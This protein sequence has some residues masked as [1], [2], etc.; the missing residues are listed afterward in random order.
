VQKKEGETGPLK[1]WRSL[2]VESELKREE[3]G[4]PAGKLQ[5]LAGRGGAEKG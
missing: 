1:S 4:R 2:S 5:G 3:H